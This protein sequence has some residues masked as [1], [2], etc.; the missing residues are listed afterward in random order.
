[1]PSVSTKGFWGFR[2]WRYCALIIDPFAVAMHFCFMINICN[3][4]AG[5]QGFP[6]LQLI[7]QT[8]PKRKEPLQTLA[9]ILKKMVSLRLNGILRDVYHEVV[10]V[11]TIDCNQ[12]SCLSLHMQDT[13]A[14]L[15]RGIDGELFSNKQATHKK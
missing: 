2:I 8:Q 15:L 5:P 11:K 9:L 7:L 13:T 10:V 6:S 4:L 12:N 14:Y 1:M 3:K